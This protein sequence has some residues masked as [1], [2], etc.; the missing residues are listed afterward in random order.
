M[1]HHR[2][3]ALNQ[4]CN[5]SAQLLRWIETQTK[6]YVSLLDFINF[7]DVRYTDCRTFHHCENSSYPNKISLEI[8][9]L[10]MSLL[11]L[12][13]CVLCDITVNFDVTLLCMHVYCCITKQMDYKMWERYKR[14]NKFSSR[15]YILQN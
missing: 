2:R 9:H 4:I 1:L 11:A 12:N 3:V 7:V 13:H 14:C 8:L 10:K 15:I 5:S 6:Q